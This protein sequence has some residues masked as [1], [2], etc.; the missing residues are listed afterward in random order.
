MTNYTII[1]RKGAWR[2]KFRTKAFNQRGA[3]ENYYRRHS[4]A[5]IDIREER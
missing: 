4:E 2:R 1:Y 3:Y 5:I